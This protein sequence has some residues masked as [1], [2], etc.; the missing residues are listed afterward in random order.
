MACAADHPAEAFATD[1]VFYL[2]GRRI[3]LHAVDP[4]LLIVDYLRRP[5]VGLTGTKKVCGQGG[6]GACTVML[7]TWSEAAG[8]AEHRAVNACLRPLATLDGCAVTTVEGAGS[9]AE[10]L[11]P[12]QY[13]V[14]VNNGSQCGF[15]TPGW[16][17]TMHAH[18]AAAGED[19]GT[20]QEIEELFDGNLC[21]C[22]GY[23]PILYAMKQ[24][25]GDWTPCGDDCMHCE[26]APGTAP[27]HRDH[28]EVA[29]PEEL[30]RPPRSVRYARGGYLWVR[31]TSLEQLLRTIAERPD[32]LSGVRLV[33]GNTS[34]GVYDRFVED[35][36]TFIDI[37][38]IDELR[39]T[40]LENGALTVGAAETYTHLLAG[41]D[42]ALAALPAGRSAG[43]AA[44]RY[45]AHRTAGTIVRN[46][47]CLAGNTMLVA[48]HVYEGEPFPSDAFTTLAALQ[49]RVQVAFAD[50]DAVAEGPAAEIVEMDLLDFATRWARDE[51]LR[52][53]GV[54]LGYRVPLPPEG[55]REFAQAYKTALREVNSHSIVNAAFRIRVAD[56]DTV[57][58]AAL[59][60]GGL[61]PIAV[62]MPRTEDALAGAPWNADT[63]E[64]VRSVLAEELAAVLEASAPRFAELPDEGFTAAYRQALGEAF[65]YKF[66][67]E[68]ELALD[69]GSV[70][71][72][73]RSAAERSRRPVS[74]G[75]QK[76]RHDHAE[77]PV[78]EPYVSSYAFLQASGEARY[79][80]D[81][82]PPHRGVEAVVAVSQAALAR[83]HYQIPTATGPQR[84]TLE[85]LGAH[86]S[87]C[88]PGFVAYVTSFDVPEHGTNILGAGND[89]VVC[90][91]EDTPDGPEGTVEWFGE[92]LGVV[93]ARDQRTAEDAAHY[94]ATACVHYDRDAVSEPLVLTFDEALEHDTRF[95]DLPPYPV[96]IETVERP[97]STFE[98]VEAEGPVAVDGVECMVVRGTQAAG[99]QI[100]FYMETQS[101]LAEPGEEGELILHP[102]TQ[103]PDGVQSGVA[104]M[105]GLSQNAVH[106]R[107]RRVGGAY[108]GKTTRSLYAAAPAALA[109]WV[110]RRPVLLRMPRAADTAMF[111]HRHPVRGSYAVAIGTGSDREADRGLLQ[112][113]QT[114]F[115]LDGGATYDCSFVVSDCI[116]LRAD[117][118]YL[119]PNYRTV[120]DVYR[121]NKASNTAFRSFGLIQGT[122]VQED[123]LEA[124]AH[125][126]GMLPEDVRERNLYS[127]GDATP[128]GQRL[129]YCYMKE[130]WDYA[131]ERSEFDRRRAECEAFNAENRWRKRGISLIPVKY[132][133]GYNVTWMEQAGAL[134]EVYEGDGSVLLRHGGIEMGQGVTIK[135]TQLAALSLNVP[136]TRLRMTETD[137]AVVPNPTSTGAST[138]TA[139]NGAA[140]REACL[141]LRD[142]LERFCLTQ[143]REH[144][145]DWCAEQGIDFWNHEHGWNDKD[146]EGRLIWDNVVKLAYMAR[147]NLS[148]QVRFRQKG[149]ELPDT[150]LS[151][152]K[153][154]EDV[155]QFVG[156]TYSAACTEVEIDVLTG[157]TTVLRTDIFYD[158][159][160]SLN[161]A[162]DVGQVEGAFVQGLGNVLTEAL[163]F[164]P[165]GSER[166]RLNTVNT[167]RYKP[168]AYTTIPLEFNV[169]LFPRDLAEDVP[170]N[171]NELLSSKEVG[172]PPLV[173]ATTVYFAV[174]HAVL[175][176]RRDRGLDGWFR[177]DSPATVYTVQA[178]CAEESA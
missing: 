76:W 78:G 58:E 121:T 161:P 85:E 6:C 30:R 56:D 88:F 120:A 159:G 136:F 135:V 177:M 114:H 65:F 122:I 98:W 1:L 24:F 77:D 139:F 125:A 54:L 71:P 127:L 93:A 61:A 142:R 8:A 21:R 126:I 68:V 5:D 162:I 145:K 149:G 84:C 107:V 17:M 175:A 103:S 31:P 99:D 43:L 178:A 110:L 50:A 42:E 22:T 32:G 167:W 176:A 89:P 90:P 81:F 13:A 4:S 130:V 62:R 20:Q 26:P 23:R 163:V 37:G 134:V 92:P 100:H 28:V 95:P 39:G 12:V 97:R 170:D 66:F 11:G 55:A 44:L 147:V 94:I 106:V 45:M 63:L 46:A 70:P 47:G 111:G 164:Q 86:L 168:P 60:F 118:A 174:K 9:V 53:S 105:L 3:H 113:W 102:S 59:V 67:L 156:Y 129:D 119:V 158:A 69:P 151:F 36:H 166:G 148:E 169:E 116:Q 109:A 48:R 64:R 140:V 73:D 112:G 132:G 138:G 131:R 16:V 128:F 123:A 74:Y 173:L 172:E 72:E 115:L 171:P 40:R 41:L 160:R 157:E 155:D 49:A 38:H 29:F 52:T 141:R 15:C 96:H 27:A 154:S 34:S 10:A 87:E 80:H 19:P 82:D 108:G 79:T 57:A 75:R 146:A 133:S 104:R 137:T 35:P 117:G 7:S 144:G 14:A 91:L 124:A 152:D 18:L 101:C 83:I 33:V 51:R 143:L 25:A 165:D 153:G 150:G 2:N